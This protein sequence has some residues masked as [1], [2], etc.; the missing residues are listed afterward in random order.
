MAGARLLP[1]V[2][3]L[4]WTALAALLSVAALGYAR[5][6]RR[7]LVS[8]RGLVLGAAAL[9]VAAALGAARDA[10]SRQFP[11]HHL[12]HAA[13]AAEAA[14]ARARLAPATPEDRAPLVL[15]G[16]LAEAPVPTASGVRFTVRPDSAARGG[17]T[18]AVRGDVLVTLVQ[19]R[20]GPLVYP[21]LRLGDRVRVAGALQGLPPRR[22]P[23]DMDYGAYLARRG[24]HA[25][26]RV[27]EADDVVFLAPAARLSDRLA[28]AVQ[29]YVRRALQARVPDGEA[30]AV[31]LALLLA[32]RSRLD[33]ETRAAFAETGLMHLLAVSGLHV[34]L[35]GMALYGLLKP[36][37]GRLGFRHA[38]AEAARAL[39]TLGVLAVYVLAT[40]ATV[41]VVRAFVMT[42]ALVGGRVLQRAPDTLNS[43]G[44]AALVLLALRPAA[45]LD[46][47]FQLSF[48]AVA[49]LVLLTPRLEAPVPAALRRHPAGGWALRSLS[50]SLAATLGTAPVLL[51]TFGAVPLAALVLNLPAIPLTGVVLGSGLGAVS[52]HGWAGPAADA[53]GALASASAGALLWLSREG[54]RDL[55]ALTLRMHLTAPALLAA[56]AAALGVLAFWPRRRA[57]AAA[58]V[59]ALA[60][61]CLSVWA[62]VLRGDA[63]P[64]LDVLFLDVG[65]GDATLLRLPGGRHVLVDA[66][67][68]DDYTDQGARTV[69]PHLR[70]FGIARLDALVLTHPDA[71]HVGGAQAV[72]EA[73][74]VGTLIHNGHLRPTETWQRTLRLADSLGVAQ[75]VVRTGDTLAL[76]PHVRLR[77]LAPDG[78]PPPEADGNDASVVLL[79]EFGRT[80][81]LLT[82]DAEAGAEAMLAARFGPLLRADVVKVGHHGSRTSSTQ[83]LVLAASAGLSLRYAVVSVAR[84][85]RYGLPN[86]EPLLRWQAA[87]AAVLQ[88]A[89]EGA[90]WLRSDGEAVRRRFWR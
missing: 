9:G 77:V 15:W 85:N 3:P 4:P 46:V 65:Q 61:A 88:T 81:F 36:V 5:A 34:L 60:L 11:P 22:N 62:H 79:A 19:P 73:L 43:L 44:A 45:L 66:G 6:A 23:A 21:A 50:A 49:A 14:E 17:R 58:G 74:P 75:R 64:H 52:L 1:G 30:R 32:D 35:V 24:V 26:L 86:A 20:E 48:S 68:R 12:A 33:A 54:A 29:A 55:G 87:G 2:P 37:L 59:V 18:L 51:A 90:V 25:T 69:V 82:G 53:L 63:R 31:L 76:D 40:G 42:A 7:R 27:R 47:G 8:L 13:A 10:A 67:L 57:R 56:S 84:R 41:S 28:G 72:L 80:R 38:R 16:R 78:P 83:P 70:R 71:D 39:G 89:D